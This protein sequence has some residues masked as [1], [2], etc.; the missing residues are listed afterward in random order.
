MIA[1]IR[2][3][4]YKSDFQL[5]NECGEFAGCEIISSSKTINDNKAHHIGV[6][7]LDWS[8]LL[9]CQFMYRVIFRHFKEG[10]YKPIYADT[11]KNKFLRKILIII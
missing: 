11:G 1:K 6:A 9:L 2:T 10:T 3:P 8:K 7:I 4:F 5:M